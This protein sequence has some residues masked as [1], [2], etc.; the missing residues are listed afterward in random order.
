MS[1]FS[2]SDLERIVAERASAS[3]DQSWTA[4]LFAAGQN[5]AAKKLGEEA[6]E[7]VIAAISQDRK[8]LTDEAADL[9][10][11]LL[12]VLKIAD[13]PLSDVFAEL[14]RRTGQSGLQEKASRPQS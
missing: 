5:K 13:I 3:P 4:K 2:L 8:N 7:T 10:Y 12:V 14:E 6:V 9:L 11:H 1:G